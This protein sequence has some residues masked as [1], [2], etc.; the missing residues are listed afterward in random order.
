MD[1][2][3]ELLHQ[4]IRELKKQLSSYK[5]KEIMNRKIFDFTIGKTRKGNKFIKII[6]DSYE[7]NGWVE[8]GR[9]K[10]SK[11]EWVWNNFTIEDVLEELKE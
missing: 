11:N 3:Q 5:A 6:Y 10:L 8:V 9:I 7:L 4:E 1:T 2:K